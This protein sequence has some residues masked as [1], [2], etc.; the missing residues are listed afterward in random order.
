MQHPFMLKLEAVTPIE[1]N[2]RN[3]SING[4]LAV[5]VVVVAAAVVLCML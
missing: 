1:S 3:I 5:F 4:I 2:Y